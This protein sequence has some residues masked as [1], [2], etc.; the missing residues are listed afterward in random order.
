MQN[1]V[2][3]VDVLPN[4]P[5]E[6]DIV[7]LRPSDRVFDSDSCCKRQFNGSF[8]VRKGHIQAWLKYLRDTA[9]ITDTSIYAMNDLLHFRRMAMSRFSSGY[10]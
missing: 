2:K 10:G 9:P 7:I 6:L 8:R 5:S 4:L 3:M 1:L